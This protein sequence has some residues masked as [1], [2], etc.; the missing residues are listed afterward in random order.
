MTLSLTNDKEET[1]P[2]LHM[3]ARKLLESL[4]G[5]PWISTCGKQGFE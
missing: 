1:P 5:V 3:L 2:L 4:P